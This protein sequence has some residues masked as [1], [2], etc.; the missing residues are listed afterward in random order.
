MELQF[1]LSAH[2][3][4]MVY[5]CVKFRENILNGFRIISYRANTASILI[6]TNG[7]NSVNIAHGVIVLVFCISSD[8][9]LHLYQVSRKYLERF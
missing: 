9:G 8:H 1:L 3:L 7:H 2:H 5:S 4:I 6:V